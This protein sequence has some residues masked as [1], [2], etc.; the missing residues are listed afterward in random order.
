M[1]GN[2]IIDIVQ[3]RHE[4]N[5]QRKGFL[6]KIFTAD[7]QLLIN[8]ALHP[9]I[10]VWSLWSMKEA[11]YKIYNR[12]TKIRSYIPQKL[13]CSFIFQNDHFI[14]GT[15]ICCGN[16]KYYTETNISNDCIHTI[17]VTHP[18][19]L[20]KVIEIEKKNISKDQY[21]IPFLTSTHSHTAQAV[22]VSHHGRFEKVVII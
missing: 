18:D 7:E 14:S 19:H 16:N 22:S 9:E 15:V 12:Q 3:S 20:K 5:W 17:A 10:I 1:I 21:G 2:D 13:K 8:K 4:S 6:E 11:A